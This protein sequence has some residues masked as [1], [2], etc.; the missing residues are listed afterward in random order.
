[1]NESMFVLKHCTLI[2]VLFLMLRRPPRSTRT[3]TLVP[4]PTLFRSDRQQP[5]SARVP[6]L[7]EIVFHARLGTVADKV[8]RLESLAAEISKH[9]PGADRDEARSAA[10]L[11]K[12]DLTTRS[13]ERRVGKEGGST[14][15]SRWL[16][17]HKKKKKTVT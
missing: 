16:P 12:A 7:K 9:V 3:D 8:S 5:L 4:Y 14:C 10:R 2:F 6:A 13:E 1:M 11:A 17:S 15:R